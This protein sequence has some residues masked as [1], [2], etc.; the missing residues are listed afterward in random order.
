[1]G[2]LTEAET[3][4]SW[5]VLLSLI[6]VVGLVEVLLVSAWLPQLTH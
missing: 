5:S 4:R 3:L 2:G 6:S 1:M